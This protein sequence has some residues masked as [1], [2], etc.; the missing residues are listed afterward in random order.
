[1]K[2]VGVKIYV[3]RRWAKTMR[4]GLKRFPRCSNRLGL[5]IDVHWTR[6]HTLPGYG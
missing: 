1:M 6:I 2:D 3:R 5:W 4:R